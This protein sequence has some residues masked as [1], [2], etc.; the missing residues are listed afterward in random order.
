LVSISA[1][2]KDATQTPY[3]VSR[4]TT[5]RLTI[6]ATSGDARR[7]DVGGDIKYFIAKPSRRF[8]AQP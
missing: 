1:G 2:R 7:G 6:P 4:M 5:D 8:H 3:V